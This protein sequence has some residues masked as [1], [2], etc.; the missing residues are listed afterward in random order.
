MKSLAVYH[1]GG[2]KNLDGKLA[3]KKK[4]KKMSWFVQKEAGFYFMLV[5]SL[6]G[7]SAKLDGFF[8]KYSYF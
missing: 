7:K 4:D 1:A 8:D 5:K 3:K 2:V 6:G